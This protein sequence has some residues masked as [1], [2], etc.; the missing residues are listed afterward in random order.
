MVVTRHVVHGQ[1]EFLRLQWGDHLWESDD[2]RVDFAFFL[3]FEQRLLLVDEG[4]LKASERPSLVLEEIWADAY[5]TCKSEPTNQWWSTLSFFFGL[6][7]EWSQTL[8]F[9]PRNQWSHQWLPLG[10]AWFPRPPSRRTAPS[11]LTFHR[12]S[13]S[14]AQCFPLWWSLT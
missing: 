14:R 2:S 12:P 8:A 3:R 7:R 9:T 6:R 13:K 11:S 4:F 10:M 5:G 1:E